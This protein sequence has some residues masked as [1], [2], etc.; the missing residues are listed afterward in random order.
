MDQVNMHEAKTQLSKLVARVE[1]GEEII[2]ARRGKPVA[3]LVG[4]EPP[5]TRRLSGRDRGLFEVPDD[6]DQPLPDEVLQEF[7]S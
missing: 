6:F 5:K 4:L 2:I 3:K 7:E 1:S